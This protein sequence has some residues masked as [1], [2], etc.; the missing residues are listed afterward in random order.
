LT[1]KSRLSYNLRAP[2]RGLEDLK[3]IL[4]K[5]LEK[6][7][8]MVKPVLVLGTFDTKEKE[9]IYLRK[10]IEAEGFGVL[11]TDVSCKTHKPGNP[12]EISCEAVAREEGKTFGTV[13]P[14]PSEPL[15]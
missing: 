13:R 12:V 6:E 3:H 4:S 7:D 15:L 5:L 10:R 8:P 11:L 1:G 2:D 9:I 14:L